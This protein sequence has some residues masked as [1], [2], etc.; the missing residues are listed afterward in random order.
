MKYRLKRGLAIALILL[1]AASQTPYVAQAS[2]T[3]QEQINEA[4]K[5]KK[6]L[7][8]E[9]EDA[10]NKI[11]DLN[12]KQSTLKKEIKSL[13]GDLE[14]IS[15]VLED[16]ENQI[17]AKEEEIA[18]T[19][20]E[21]A[22]A[23]ETEIAQYEAMMK[24]I[25][26]MYED[27]ETLYLDII[28]QAKS[29]SD[30]ITL[31]NY[32]DQLASYDQTKFNEYQATRIE[33]EDLDAKLKSDH[34]EL[35]IL[36]AD[37]EAEKKH[38]QEVIS[39][40]SSK[41]KKYDLMIDDAEAE[42]LEKEKELEDKNA[43]IEALKKKLAEEIRLSQLSANSVWRDLS[44]ISFDDGDR[45]LLANLIYCEAGG[46][47]YEG[48][49]AVGAVVI[50]RL[51]SPVYPSTMSGVIYQKS[52]FSP[53]GSGRLAYALSVNK[54]TE[55]CYRAADAAMGGATNVGNCVYFRTPI[56]GLEGIRIGN[57]IFY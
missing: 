51:R 12:S 7:E 54:A 31:S 49:V 9:L 13:N 6:Q 43:D 14:K 30:L 3:T 40:T 32:V 22:L 25:K 48:Q 20:E 33:I 15:E 1:I 45:Y 39:E 28:F 24:R 21:L 57:H 23:R 8:K 5:E 10:D 47:P 56:E 50:N 17:T 11:D 18:R 27:S 46:E 44:E 19:Q 16:L 4:E 26:F 37:A 36:K 52:Q 2:K 41:V 55:S 42:Y 35:E 53:A 29:F 38:V 34:V